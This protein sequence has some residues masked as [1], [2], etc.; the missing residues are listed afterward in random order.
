VVISVL[1]PCVFVGGH[2]G[3]LP[4]GGAAIGPWLAP[5]WHTVTRLSDIQRSI[6]CSTAGCIQYSC[7]PPM[8]NTVVC[9]NGAR[10]YT[11]QLFSEPQCQDQ[12][13]YF[14]SFSKRPLYQDFVLYSMVVSI[15][16]ILYSCLYQVYSIQPSFSPPKN[17][18][19]ISLDDPR[20]GT[21]D[22]PYAATEMAPNIATSTL[23]S[24]HDM[25]VSN[26]LTVPKMVEAARRNERSIRRLA[27]T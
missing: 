16:S 10:V 6:L 1:A 23:M 2:L 18:L 9:K 21:V 25:T 5:A 12:L 3:S 4:L 27:L 20:N 15:T 7:F 24:I 26:E 19:Q 13:N 8:L 11:L 22:L 14:H 17:S